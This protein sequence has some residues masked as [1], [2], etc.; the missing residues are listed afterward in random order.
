MYL[1]LRYVSQLKS[2]F[3][4]DGTGKF[5][6]KTNSL[7]LRKNIVIFSCISQ[8]KNM[9]LSKFKVFVLWSSV[10]KPSAQCS[11]RNATS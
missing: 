2:N 6:C 7:V 5:Y 3:L 4:V 8:I 1:I 9:L 10:I 11:G